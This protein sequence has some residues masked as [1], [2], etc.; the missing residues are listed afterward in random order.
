MTPLAQEI[1]LWL[2]AQ[3]GWVSETQIC[4]RFGVDERELRNT[5]RKPGLLSDFAISGNRGFKHVRNA[6][7]DE[8]DQFND[9]IRH[10][11]ICQLRRLKTLRATRTNLLTGKRPFVVEIKTGQGV[12]L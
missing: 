4:E 7:I 8:W 3:Y 10:H 2:L 12:L 9:R 6:T 11:S 1:E 5:S